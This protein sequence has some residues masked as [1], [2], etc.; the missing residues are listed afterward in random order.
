V[1]TA[2]P[3][4]VLNGRL[5]D[6][7]GA[8]TLLHAMSSE[9]L[10]PHTGT[11]SSALSDEFFE[12]LHSINIPSSTGDSIS[13][14]LITGYT[15]TTVNGT[16]VVR[17]WRW[18]GLCSARRT[19]VAP[20]PLH[21][22]GSELTPFPPQVYLQTSSDVAPLIVIRGSTFTVIPHPDTDLDT[23]F[24]NAARAILDAISGVAVPG[25]GRRL[26]QPIPLDGVTPTAMTYGVECAQGWYPDGEYCYQFPTGTGGCN[27]DLVNLFADP[28][29]CGE[30]GLVAPD[31]SACCGGVVVPDACC[32]GGVPNCGECGPEAPAGS[33]CCGGVVTPD[34]CCVGGVPVKVDLNTDP[35]NCGAC[36]AAID[37]TTSCCLNGNSVRMDFTISSPSCQL[38][39]GDATCV[40]GLPAYMVYTHTENHRWG[41]VS[42]QIGTYNTQY[43]LTFYRYCVPW[44][45]MYAELGYSEWNS[46]NVVEKVGLSCYVVTYN[47]WCSG[48]D[49]GNDCGGY[50]LTPV[51]H[52]DDENA[53]GQMDLFPLSF[54][55]LPCPCTT[56]ECLNGRDS[57]DPAQ[58]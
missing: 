37:A 36:G 15:R 39:G 24:G 51:S 6:A 14:F 16:V 54:M 45:P 53:D 5:V 57:Y 41:P 29:N 56:D 22:R 23:P 52:G 26:Q 8:G 4:A 40:N 44:D 25:E 48:P 21:G 20:P 38:C 35:D 3:I 49:C 2:Q 18:R 34:T 42:N 46:Y 50:P 33:V 43:F 55:E 32:V 28:N 11:L 30:C 13:T 7:K 19:G 9:K 1:K 47:Q 17:V 10:L 27:G 31:G 58:E 12:R